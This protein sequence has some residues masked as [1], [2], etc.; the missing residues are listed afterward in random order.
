MSPRPTP[1][2]PHVVAAALL[3]GSALLTTACGPDGSQPTSAGVAKGPAA[4][5]PVTPSARPPQ[6]QRTPAQLRQALLSADEAPAGMQ[7]LPNMQQSGQ[8]SGAAV[9]GSAAC[10]TLV[11]LLAS[12]RR[13]GSH[14]AAR[15]TFSAAKN[16]ALLDETL[17]A[18]GSVGSAERFLDTYRRAVRA[19][20]EVTLQTP[21]LRGSGL[22]ARAVRWPQQG[23]H[24]FAARFTG[25]SGGLKG[26]DALLV[27]VQVR[28]VVVGMTF[29]GVSPTAAD[30]ATSHA[31]SAVRQ[32]LATR[33][34]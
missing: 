21:A 28:D 1:R 17:D 34:A 16:S 11:N 13:P 18:M 30:G 31:V 24:S 14:A 12:D 8:G 23:D 29:L 3:A 5:T 19:C 4:A 7:V 20:P 10:R 9:S 6:L 32:T 22:R 27:V 33:S 26:F 2:F 25:R 15:V